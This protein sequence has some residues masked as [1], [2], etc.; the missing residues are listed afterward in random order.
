[1]ETVDNIDRPEIVDAQQVHRCAAA[2][3]PCDHRVN[4]VARQFADLVNGFRPPFRRRQVGIDV[5]IGDIDPDYAVTTG[6]QCG[7]CGFTKPARC[8]R[9][10]CKPIHL[11]ILLSCI[12][13]IVP[14]DR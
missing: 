5:A 12:S 14:T 7:T 8:P 6:F 11:R 4:M 10:Y 9:H 13:V 2:A 3:R 1:V